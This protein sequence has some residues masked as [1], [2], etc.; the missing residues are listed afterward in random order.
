V[1]TMVQGEKRGKAES[2]AQ[3][4]QRSRR[5]IG[6]VAKSWSVNTVGSGRET[7]GKRKASHRGHGGHRGGLASG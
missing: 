5:G 4:S 2:I 1:A 3:R 6:S 7:R